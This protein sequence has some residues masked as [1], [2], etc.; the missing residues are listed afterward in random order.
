MLITLYQSLIYGIIYLLFEAY[1][2]SF[3]GHRHWKP[4]T[5]ALPF[6]ALSV[7]TLIGLAIV[8]IN[9]LTVFARQTRENSGKIVPETRLPM[10]FFGGICVPI[11]IFWFAWTSNPSIPWAAQVLAGIPIGMGLFIIFIQGFNYIIDV[12]LSIANSAIA[13]NTVVRSLFAFGFPMFAPAMYNGL[14]VSWASSLLGFIMLAM[15]PVPVI[16]YIYGARIRNMSKYSPN[17]S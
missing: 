6:L 10:M 13:A 12:Y 5:A 1:P 7:G 16:F 11:G 3:I 4:T 9:I 8:L 15:V 2:I 14:G 17:K